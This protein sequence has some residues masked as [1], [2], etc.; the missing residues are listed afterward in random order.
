DKVGA[1]ARSAD[2]CAL[3]L[4]A[5]SGPDPADATTLPDGAYSD[6]P[7]DRP[8]RVGWLP[9]AFA[10]LPPE[11]ATAVDAARETMRKAG[12]TVAD[13]ELPAGPWDETAT[14]II[15]AESA[16]AHHGL[17]ESGRMAEL[18]D[19]RD[20][21][22]GY[23]NQ[24]VT[25]AD[26]LRAQRVRGI[27]QRKADGLFDR[28]DVLAAPPLPVPAPLLTADLSAPDTFGDNPT[29]PLGAIGNLCGWPAVSV[30]CGFAG[31]LPV[32]VAF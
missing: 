19:A 3:V 2:C 17:I 4:Q 26:Y 28:F 20:R 9:K 29:D 27:L 13:A 12:A 16:T 21:I 14:V 11:V 5:V 7:A 22:G 23:V 8:L 24:Q 32:A 15:S 31:G 6:A 10:K 25:A 18:R 1:L 30:P